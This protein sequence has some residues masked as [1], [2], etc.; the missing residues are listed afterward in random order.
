MGMVF[1]LCLKNLVLLK[2]NY[3]FEVEILG[4][5]KELNTMFGRTIIIRLVVG[6]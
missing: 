3:F 5:A 6:L 4:F 1:L 2:T